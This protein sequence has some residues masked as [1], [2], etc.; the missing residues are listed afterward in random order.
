MRAKT[1]LL[2]SLMFC[3]FAL[4][5]VFGARREMKHVQNDKAVEFQW[6]ANWLSSEQQRHIAQARLIVFEVMR[7]WGRGM[8]DTACRY[9]IGGE[10]GLDPEFGA[11]AL[12]DPD[13]T[14]SCNSIP[15]LHA[16][17]VADQ[18]YFK[19]AMQRLYKSVLAE[20]DNRNP[21]EYNAILARA[22]RD[23]DDHVQKV[24]LV[25]MDFSWVQEEIS[26]T[27]LPTDGH[28]L[29][30]DDAGIVVAGSRNV[31]GWIDKSVAQTP[32]YRH[33][34]AARESSYYGTGFAGADSIVV[35]HAIPTGAGIMHV[36]VDAPRRTPAASE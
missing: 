26:Q 2:L 20:A 18:M 1:R 36:V 10:P 25:A 14:I 4:L 15:W 35:V 22:M 31:T 32:F 27:R 13:G 30:I 7:A 12:A 34:L 11:F 23:K 21:L 19:H 16:R 5:T 17:N 3:L 28:V 8:A 29:L 6:T 24:V 33:V 9:G